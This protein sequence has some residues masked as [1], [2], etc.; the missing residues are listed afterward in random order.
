[1][2]SVAGSGERAR[3][4]PSDRWVAPRFF[5]WF[6]LEHELTWAVETLSGSSKAAVNSKH[7][8]YPLNVHTRVCVY[9][10]EI[11]PLTTFGALRGHCGLEFGSTLIAFILQPLSPPSRLFHLSSSFDRPYLSF[12]GVLLALEQGW[13]PCDGF[14]ISR[15][16]GLHW[17]PGPPHRKVGVHNRLRLTQH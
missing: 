12:L 6:V 9:R 15:I 4:S 5:S 14:P 1:M 8:F 16:S 13:L 10:R 3:A 11:A 17:A 7:S 2:G